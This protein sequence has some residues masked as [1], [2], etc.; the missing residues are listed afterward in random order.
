MFLSLP[1][2]QQPNIPIHPLFNIIYG[3]YLIVMHSYL[4]H[5][6]INHLDPDTANH[7]EYSYLFYNGRWSLGDAMI[8]VLLCFNAT[9][10][11][12]QSASISGGY[13]LLFTTMPFLLGYTSLLDYSLLL[14][15]S[16]IILFAFYLLCLVSAQDIEMKLRIRFLKL[17][18]LGHALRRRDTLINSILPKDISVAIRKGDAQKLSAYHQNVSIL[19]CSIVDFGRHSSIS[20]AEV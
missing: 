2:F 12:G 8:F 5:Q 1:K 10:R 6:Q 14:T 18:E 15:P 13:I 19:F 3:V 4:S 7:H 11:F 9:L 17:S 20:H 16:M